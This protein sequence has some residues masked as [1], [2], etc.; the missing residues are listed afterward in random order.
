MSRALKG[1]ALEGVRAAALSR[2]PI[3]L[4]IRRTASPHEFY[5]YPGRFSPALAAAIVEAF[6]GPGDVVADYFVG[7]GT[8]LVEAMRSGRMAIGSDINALAVFVSRVKTRQYTAGELAQVV[9]WADQVEPGHAQS[10]TLPSDE[11]ALAYFRNLTSDA[12][13]DQRRVLLA[14]VAGLEAVKSHKARAFGRCVLLRTAQWA[15]DMR[16]EVPD[17][18]RLLKTLIDNA[19][20]MTAVATDV[21]AQYRAAASQV[22]AAGRPRCLILHQGLPGVADIP[23][24]ARY[25]APR[26]VLTSPP[27]PGVYVNYHR[28]KIS[29]RLETP[30][31]FFLAGELDGNGLAY[32]T[33]SARSRRSQDVYFAKL[34][35]AFKD[36]ARIC[37][38]RTHVLQVVGFSNVEQQL[39][40]YL[41]AMR[42][43]GFDE[44]KFDA[45]A[46]GP[47][48]RLWRDVPGRR[49][50]ARAG[51][52]L[53]V[54]P[55]T[56]REVVLVHQLAR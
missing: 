35:T 22:N 16:Q 29:G 2:T 9:E 6:S 32:Y 7:G 49:W 24:I 11:S 39:S 21:T 25:P 26:L 3:S 41:A 10:A 47:D 54:A 52:R 36:V 4:G 8:T 56:A 50:W 20:A 45:L 43:A 38:A 37:D 46:T 1:E 53:D 28:W 31:P 30:F 18:E 48:G 12:F 23:R 27:Y 19:W 13:A 34:E 42:Q 40:R 33:M 17:A 15:L 5:R 55:H 51:D 14:A 44:I